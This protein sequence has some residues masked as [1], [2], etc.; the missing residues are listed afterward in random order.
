MS[1]SVGERLTV[2][3]SLRRDEKSVIGSSK[4]VAMALQSLEFLL[5]SLGLTLGVS[6]SVYLA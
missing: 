5:F 4:G 3:S 6:W 2:D 1:G